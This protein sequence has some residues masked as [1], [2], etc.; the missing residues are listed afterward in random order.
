MES[1]VC[2]RGAGAPSVGYQAGGRWRTATRL[3]LFVA[4]HLSPRERDR[5]GRHLRHNLPSREEVALAALRRALPRLIR[6]P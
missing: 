6:K 4:V 5:A 2:H 3:P 1:V